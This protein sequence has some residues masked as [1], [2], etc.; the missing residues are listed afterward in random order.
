M[1]KVLIVEDDPMVAEFNKRYLEEL[2]GFTLV[3]VVHSPD[4]AQE[5]LKKKEVDLL[6]L[7]NFMPGKTGLELIRNLRALQTRLDVI[8]ITAASDAET[9]RAALSYGA[10]DY[11]IKPF[12]FDRFKQALLRYKGK[13]DLLS[14]QQVFNQKELDQ[15]ILHEQH[16][17][18][19]AESLPKGLTKATLKVVMDAI[20]VKKSNSFS[21]EDI[22]EI[23]QISRVSIRKYL[24][25]LK[26]IGVLGERMTYGTIGRPI[27]QYV[28]KEM[29]ADILSK[30][31]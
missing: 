12:E 20:Q 24:K 21:T 18:M 3:D 16:Q 14:N 22:A 30:Y 26:S 11:L 1:I 7:D 27:Y 2:D 10:F 8:F 23:T 28:Y 29:N 6:L 31:D 19:E 4:A 5:V 17:V 15:Q 9:I 25:F 13:V